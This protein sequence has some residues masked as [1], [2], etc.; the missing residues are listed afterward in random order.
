M[1]PLIVFG[2]LPPNLLGV[3]NYR[4]GVITIDLR[5]DMRSPCLV[6]LH[7]LTHWDN[8]EMDE[9]EVIARSWFQWKRMNQAERLELYRK[10]FR[11]TRG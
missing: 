2:N 7:E 3:C 8:P 4:K 11:R 1:R 9:D 10:L 6:L 5:K